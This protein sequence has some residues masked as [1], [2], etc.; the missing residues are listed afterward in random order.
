VVAQ[1]SPAGARGTEGQP[2]A[3]AAGATVGIRLGP[4]AAW[5]VVLRR[6]VVVAEA[7]EPHEPH[8]QQADV[9]NPEADHED[10]T[11][12]GHDAMVPPMGER[13]GPDECSRARLGGEGY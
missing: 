5:A 9:E 4:T 7:E 3:A 12:G 6:L 8:D 13:V 11:L 1:P 2:E 10:P